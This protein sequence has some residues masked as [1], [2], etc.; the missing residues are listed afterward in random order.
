MIG[1]LEGTVLARL[2]NAL[3]LHTATGVGYQVN[4][5][6][7]LLAQSTPP[8][9]ILRLF[10]ATVVRDNEISLYG[11]AALEDKALF[12]LLL[13]A[14]GV[15]PRLALA[16]LSAFRPAELR[17]AIVRQDVALLATIPGV[18]RKTASRLCVELGD[19]MGGAALSAAESLEGPGDLISALTNLGFPEKDVVPVVR[20]L[21]ELSG[22]GLS[23]AEQVK[24]ALSLLRKA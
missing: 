10:V 7:P 4:V 8:E 15:G 2:D 14:S 13:K 11:F 5:P 20:Q 18:G 1:Y 22:Q 21:S 24:E 16:F 6:L 12:E 19:R 3:L 17:G 9:T 23:F